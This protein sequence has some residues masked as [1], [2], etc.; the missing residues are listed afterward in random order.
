VVFGTIQRIHQIADVLLIGQSVGS[1]LGKGDDGFK[2]IDDTLEKLNPGMR[3]KLIPSHQR[4]T[5]IK[6]RNMKFSF[7]QIRRNLLLIKIV[8]AV[9]A[10]N[11]IVGTGLLERGSEVCFYQEPSN[12]ECP[13]IFDDGISNRQSENAPINVKSGS[14]KVLC[15]RVGDCQKIHPACSPLQ[16]DQSP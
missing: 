13:S 9:F 6:M 11:K 1:F 16:F 8:A 3:F 15:D 7:C 14:R 5:G 2:I 12:L 10:V 4:H